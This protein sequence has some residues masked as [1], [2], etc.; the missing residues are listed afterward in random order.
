M[1]AWSFSETLDQ[2][3]EFRSD[4]TFSNSLGTAYY[5]GISLLEVMG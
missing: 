1:L 3:G 4:P 5:F 2:S